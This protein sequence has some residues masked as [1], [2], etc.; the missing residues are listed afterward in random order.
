MHVIQVYNS[1][2]HAENVVCTTNGFLYR[3]VTKYSATLQFMGGNYF[4]CNL[5]LFYF[6]KC[7]EINVRYSDLQKY[8]SYANVI[9]SVSIQSTVS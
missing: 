3:D 4:K 2:L 6:I 9:N 8:S 1:M 7:N 5:I